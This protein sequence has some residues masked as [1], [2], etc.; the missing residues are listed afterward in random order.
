MEEPFQVPIS[1]YLYCP[2]NTYFKV[3]NLHKDKYVTI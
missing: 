2:L 1:K 3:T